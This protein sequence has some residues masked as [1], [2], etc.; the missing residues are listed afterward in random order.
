[1]VGTGFFHECG[2]VVEL[3]DA[4]AARYIERGLAEPV[5]A[6]PPKVREAAAVVPPEQAT[7][8]NPKKKTA[9]KPSK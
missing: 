5:A 9:R 7:K 1:M 8:P 6:A 2:D 4:T 3:D